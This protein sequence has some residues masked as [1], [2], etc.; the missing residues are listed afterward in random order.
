MNNWEYLCKFIYETEWS[1]EEVE[2]DVKAAAMDFRDKHE[3]L[4]DI[5]D[6][7]E[8]LVSHFSSGEPL[9][10]EELDEETQEKLNNLNI[11]DHI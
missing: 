3:R 4:K 5:E 2:R 7:L 10:F 11:W 9:S 8:M 1:N 6:P